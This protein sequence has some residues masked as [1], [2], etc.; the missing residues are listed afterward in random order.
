MR[1]IPPGPSVPR[2]ESVTDG[3]NLLSDRRIESGTVK[4][5]LEEIA[6]PESFEAR[7]DGHYVRAAEMFCTDPRNQRYDVSFLLP[8]ETDAGLHFLE[9]NLGARTLARIPIEVV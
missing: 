3:T 4:V 1:V 9:M 2:V 5:Q 7:V 8:A 6:A